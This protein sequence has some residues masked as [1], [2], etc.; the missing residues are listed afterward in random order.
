V[1]EKLFY[2]FSKEV[3]V[4]NKRR[5]A[6]SKKHEVVIL[7]AGAV[8]CSIAYHLAKKGVRFDHH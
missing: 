8:G 4:N 6:M 5:Q 3:G 2:D 7:G 1:P